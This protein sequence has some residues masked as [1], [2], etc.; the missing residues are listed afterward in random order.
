LGNFRHPGH[1]NII[2]HAINSLISAIGPEH[3]FWEYGFETAMTI[4]PNFFITGILTITS[5]LL[6]ILWSGLFISRKYGAGI[7]LLLF[8]ILLL[9]GGGFT[10]F[11]MALFAVIAAS[12]INKLLNWWKNHFPNNLKAF[13]VNIWLIVLIICILVSLFALVAAIFGWP[14]TVFFSAENTISINWIIGLGTIIFMVLTVISAVS[15]DSQRKT[16]LSQR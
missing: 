16:D 4:I 6:I 2:K 12:K 15:Y 10:P 13:F 14:L 11:N 5:G 7:L 8:F 9:S 3:R 1:K